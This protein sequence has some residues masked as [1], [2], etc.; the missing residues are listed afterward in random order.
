MF[1]DL[2]IRLKKSPK[3]HKRKRK[4]IILPKGLF[5][6]TDFSAQ[7]RTTARLCFL[8]RAHTAVTLTHVP[9]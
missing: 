1:D 8:K 4:T 5:S 9:N 7:C 2:Y 3:V 6:D